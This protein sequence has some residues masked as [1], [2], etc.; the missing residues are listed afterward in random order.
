M[1]LAIYR[2][3][4]MLE[5]SS[6]VFTLEPG[7]ILATG[8]PAGVGAGRKPPLYLKCGD[9][10]RVEIEHIGYIGNRVVPEP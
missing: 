3:T 2:F 5:E 9:V 6:A 7:D 8:S 4:E 1:K 10:V